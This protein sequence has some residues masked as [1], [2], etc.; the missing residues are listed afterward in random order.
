LSNVHDLILRQLQRNPTARF[1]CKH[2]E[3]SVW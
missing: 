1:M 3:L 2:S